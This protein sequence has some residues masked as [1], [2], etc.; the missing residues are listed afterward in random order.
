MDSQDCPH[1]DTFIEELHR[2]H[3][4]FPARLLV[5]FDVDAGDS[6]LHWTI[7]HCTLDQPLRSPMIMVNTLEGNPAYD[8]ASQRLIAVFFHPDR[9]NHLVSSLMWHSLHIAI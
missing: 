2:R 6:G 3:L 1:S 5:F 8:V 4:R 7:L 9:P